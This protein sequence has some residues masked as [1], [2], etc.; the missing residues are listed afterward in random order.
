MYLFLQNWHAKSAT[1]TVSA[2]FDDD[3]LYL[4]SPRYPRGVVAKNC[5]GLSINV[6]EIEN[7]VYF[8]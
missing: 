4:I 6:F 8:A 5:G 1:I 7:H 2:S 3:Y